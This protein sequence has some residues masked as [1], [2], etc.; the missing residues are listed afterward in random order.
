ME[1]LLRKIAI[2]KWQP[3]GLLIGSVDELQADVFS[4]CLKT[5][6]NTLSVWLTENTDWE[7]ESVLD[8]LAALFSTADGPSRTDV[9]FIKKD[10]ISE[11]GINILESK[12]ASS[13]IDEINDRHLNLAGLNFSTMKDVAS[14]ILKI[15]SEDSSK[16]FI[17]RY[18]EKQVLAIVKRRVELK[19]INIDTLCS[20]WKG[21]L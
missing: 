20:R 13:A 15:L 1:Y 3:S 11:S 2:A 12:G 17:K 18:N 14:V 21:K 8:I 7:S 6:G 5:Q 10:T 4:A 16:S 9:V 19:K